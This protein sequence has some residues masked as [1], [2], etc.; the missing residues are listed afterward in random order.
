M[1]SNNVLQNIKKIERISLNPE[2]VLVVNVESEKSMSNMDMIVDNLTKIF[3][4]NKVIITTG[5][6]VTFKV[7]GPDE[8]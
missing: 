5:D 3:P 6:N 8:V 7:I 1:D 4:N 2:D